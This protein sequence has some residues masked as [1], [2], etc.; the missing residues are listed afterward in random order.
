MSTLKNTSILCSALTCALPAAEVAGATPNEQRPNIIFILADDLGY[1]DVCS[2]AHRVTGTP[3]DSMFFETP[4]IDRLV[5]E[6]MAFS[7]AYVCPLSSP[8]RS[9]LLT[10]K[11]AARLGFN[12]RH[13]GPG[14]VVHAE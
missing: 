10:G 7:N 12:D 9:S 6:G 8:T 13:A 1:M 4:H 14:Y 5:E 2:F 11:Y 3:I